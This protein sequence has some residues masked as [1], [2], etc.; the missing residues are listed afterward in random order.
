MKVQR[1][2]LLIRA[3][4]AALAIGP[5]NGW[6]QSV[7][8]QAPDRTLSRFLYLLAPLPA[9]AAADYDA[10]SRSLLDHANSLPVLKGH[11]KS[12]LQR[13][14]AAGF[15]SLPLPG[16]QSLLK[17]MQ[18]SPE[19]RYLSNPAWGVLSHKPTWPR[20]GYEGASF[21]LGGYLHR[22]FDDIDWLP[23]N[24]KGGQ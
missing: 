18:A 8:A 14:D 15:M 16:Q 19:F 6:A 21:P 22:G 24:A 23:A 3:L 20:I 4:P 11:V 10:A 13:L 2:A 17:S 12:L 7:D 9:F 1:R 5:I